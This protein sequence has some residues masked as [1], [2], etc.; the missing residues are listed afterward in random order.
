MRST[1]NSALFAIADEGVAKQII[2]LA[3]YCGDAMIQALTNNKHI[4]SK[5]ELYMIEHN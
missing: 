5:Y 2:V 4:T 1:I 3:N